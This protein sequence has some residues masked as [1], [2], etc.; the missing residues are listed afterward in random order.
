MAPDERYYRE[1]L[2]YL[3]QYAKL[4]ARENPQLASFLA[5]KE[6]DP[7]VERLME[8]FAFLSGRLREKIE[9]EYPEV[10]I[11]LLNR[12]QPNFLRPVPAMTIIEYMPD[13]RRLTAPVEITR[14]EQI[15]NTPLDDSQ[16]ADLP[17]EEY[18]ADDGPPSCIFTICR[19]FWLL[20]L[21]ISDIE[22]HSS[23]THG[24][25]DITFVTPKNYR[26]TAEDFSRLRF[27]LGGD[28][29]NRS[30]LYLWLCRY[31]SGA[32]LISR[33]RHYTQ[34][35]L[36]L[37][38]AGF[39]AEDSLLPWPSRVHAG[40]RILQEYLCFPDAM[41]FFDLS[42]VA[43]P[44]GA[45]GDTFTLR[46]QFDRPLPENLRISRDSLRLHCTPAI[47]LFSHR[48]VPFTP[49]GTCQEY[50]LLTNRKHP[51]RYEIFCVTGI[52]GQEDTPE[53]DNALRSVARSRE[54]Q[55]PLSLDSFQHRLE[56]HRD[57]QDLYWQHRTKP[58]LWRD[59][60][61][62]VIRFTHSDGSFPDP[63][64]FHHEPVEAALIC[65]SGD[66]PSALKPGD[67]HR[68]VGQNA[69][70]ASFR[71]I[72]IPTPSLPAVTDGVL[73]WSLLSAMTLNYLALNDVEVLRDTLRTFDR[74]G[75]H[76][77]LMARLS[78]EKL[79]ALE[80]LETI[81]TD[82]L[83]TGIPVRG[84]SS[85]LYINPQPF[86]CEG[87]IYLLGTVLSHFFALYASENSWHMLT[88]I[89]TQTQEV[90]RW[91]EKTGQFPVM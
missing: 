47:N 20:P 3:R 60:P 49:D 62:H 1:E 16:E 30:Q 41:Y 54:E 64:R 39:E 69:S 57:R 85:T 19:D 89:N 2:N 75:I 26:M 82:R 45:P 6:A 22:Q 4:L 71:N 91:T 7:D 76:T 90:W 52:H 79:N 58:A 65:T 11:P 83:F 68:A 66:Q 51:D 32:E 9:D 33:G 27:W 24:M 80:K 38:P 46:L 35:D 25:I 86:T 28:E 42:G 87:E 70:T 14:N 29:Y 73:H 37:T 36:A 59:R 34:P 67:I 48:A 72:T 50:P 8:G 17:G 21:H 61:D 84:L 88:I 55:G 31:R 10:T 63:G 18:G 78:P 5:H 12:L 13:I 43:L 77:P 81:P 74:C 44:P 56:Y 53:R 23:A 15:M 40:Y